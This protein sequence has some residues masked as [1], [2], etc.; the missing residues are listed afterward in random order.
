MYSFYIVY[1]VQGFMFYLHYI[2]TSCYF[3][4]FITVNFNIY[5]I[6]RSQISKNTFNY[7]PV[8]FLGSKIGTDY[9]RRKRLND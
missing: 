3:F 6:T 7:R 1:N 9:F 2:S 4:Q 5:E 8:A